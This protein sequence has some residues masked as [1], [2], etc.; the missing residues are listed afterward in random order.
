MKRVH[1]RAVLILLVILIPLA[2]VFYYVRNR[3]QHLPLVDIPPVKSSGL[4][5]AIYED[6][7]NRGM[8]VSIDL[9]G[10]V[11]HS[12]GD[13]YDDSQPVWKSPD[14]RRVFL[15]SNRTSDGSYQLFEWLPDRDNEPRQLTPNGSSRSSPWFDA[16]GQAIIMTSR[17]VIYRLTY[18]GLR[19]RSLFPPGMRPDETAGAEG[20]VIIEEGKQRSD[21][22]ILRA[23]RSLSEVLEGEAFEEGFVDSS[24][25]YFLGNYATARGYSIIYQNLSPED[26]SQISP[27]PLIAGD[28]VEIQM[29]SKEPKSV[30]S[31]V[32]FKYPII[33]QVPPERIRPDGTVERDF[34]SAVF[35]VDLSFQS[36]NPY[37]P[38]FLDAE[39]KVA[40]AHIKISPNQEEIALV[41]LEKSE[42]RWESKGLLIAPLK[43]GGI[44]QAREITTGSISDIDWSP[45]GQKLTFIKDGHVF[46][47]NR[48]GSGEKQLTSGAGKYSQPRFSPQR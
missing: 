47:I 35:I 25:K 28:R 4:I 36:Q 48:D 7:A 19:M 13:A 41:R 15:I 31:V 22:A 5:A 27:R 44:M 21:D 37:V 6:E 30:I 1:I 8:V 39:D 43:E 14:G 3:P 45:D 34:V 46:V 42:G 38:L 9:N 40:M 29:F 20:G 10:N 11:R 16:N 33:S 12:K 18:P 2:A 26:D 23:W 32:N 24:G 17:G